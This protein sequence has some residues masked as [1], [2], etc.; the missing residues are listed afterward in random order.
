M[1][2]ENR[3]RTYWF[4]ITLVAVTFFSTSLYAQQAETKQFYIGAGGSYAVENFFD[5]ADFENSLVVN[6]KFGYHLHPLAD[7]EFDFNYLD[8]FESK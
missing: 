8:E 7:I 2:K 1:G 5:D 3:M 6:F 4:F